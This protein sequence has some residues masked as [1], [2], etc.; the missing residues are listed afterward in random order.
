M[1]DW[2]F[3]GQPQSGSPDWFTYEEAD[4]GIALPPL[5]GWVA[6]TG[7]GI[8]TGPQNTADFC[9]R[10]PS[11]E[12]STPADVLL[13]GFPPLALAAGAYARLGNQIKAAK[14]SALCELSQGPNNGLGGTPL[15]GWDIYYQDE[16]ITF[17]PN[18]GATLV[19]VSDDLPAGCT[20]VAVKVTSYTGLLSQLLWSS[21][22]GDVQVGDARPF[23]GDPALVTNAHANAAAFGNYFYPAI[24]AGASFSVPTRV[25]W[26]TGAADSTPRTLVFSIAYKPAAVAA[27]VPPPPMPDIPGYPTGSPCDL[28]TLPDLCKSLKDLHD[29]VDVLTRNIGPAPG[30]YEGPSVKPEPVLPLPTD[31]DAPVPLKPVKKPATAVGALIKV[32]VIPDYSSRYGTSPIFYPNIGHVALITADGPLAS[33]LLKHNPM[34]IEP[35]PPYVTG[36]QLDLESGVSATVTWLFPPTDPPPPPT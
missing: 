19:W 7:M 15:L 23:T 28:V 24:A 3:G 26:W 18:A 8:P 20:A 27:P 17:T 31:P 30:P 2:P 25:V 4:V 5:A 29:K 34:V 21:V 35:L 13:W 11:Q 16:T 12:F 6:L 1:P 14:W 36:V 10:L 33:T 22:N 9:R 32:T